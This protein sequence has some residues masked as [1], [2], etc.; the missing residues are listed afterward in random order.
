M[1]QE[2]LPGIVLGNQELERKEPEIEKEKK[3]T[4]FFADV[5]LALE[6]GGGFQNQFQSSLSRF[7]PAHFAHF[8]KI[9]R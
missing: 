3:P 7:G 9:V 8:H 1:M 2:P 6:E 4:K 5:E